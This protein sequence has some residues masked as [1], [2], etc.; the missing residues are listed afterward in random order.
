[1]KTIEFICAGAGVYEAVNYLHSKGLNL[2]AT[3]FDIRRVETSSSQE[4]EA[5]SEGARVEVL[6][7]KNLIRDLAPPTAGMIS[8]RH[9]FEP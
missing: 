9:S 1:M 4:M 2:L 3:L 8:T 5:L 6:K 7:L